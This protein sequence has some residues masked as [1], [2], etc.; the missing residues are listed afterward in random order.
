MA[1]IARMAPLLAKLNLVPVVVVTVAR[2]AMISLLLQLSRI[3]LSNYRNDLMSA[4]DRYLSK[5]MIPWPTLRNCLAAGDLLADCYRILAWVAT[6]TM[7]IETGIGIGGGEDD[8]FIMR[9]DRAQFLFSPFPLSF[10]P[11]S[12]RRDESELRHW[13]G[14]R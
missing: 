5:T 7:E 13:T 6:A 1:M 8:D 4:V 11:F 9:D 12:S 10:Q 3:Q 2:L 14:G